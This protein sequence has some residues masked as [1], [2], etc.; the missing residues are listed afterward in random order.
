MYKT[1]HDTA[2]PSL[3]DDRCQ[4]VSDADRRLRSSTA[5]SCVV[6]RTSTRLGDR[7]FDVAGP[8]S[9]E[10][11]YIVASFHVSDGYSRKMLKTQCS[12]ATALVTFAFRRRFK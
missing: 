4:L 9:I 12:M 7:S 1:L 8:E 5:L 11:E 10:Q 3:S 6:P 2:P